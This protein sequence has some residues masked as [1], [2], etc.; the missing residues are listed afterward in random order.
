MHAQL[1]LDGG[2]VMLGSVSDGNDAYGKILKQPD[3]IGGCETGSACILV[4]DA[5]AVYARVKQAG[6]EIEL[7]IHDQDYGGRGFFCRD[8]EGHVWYVTS[9]NPWA[10]HS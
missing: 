10:G 8:L 2:M 7:E 3:E 6:G 9:Y 5:D 4:S 1:T